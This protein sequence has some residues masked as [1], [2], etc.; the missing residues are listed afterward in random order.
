M[1]E[2]P[3]IAL[4]RHASRP[5]TASGSAS[6]SNARA[7]GYPGAAPRWDASRTDAPNGSAVPSCWHGDCQVHLQSS[8]RRPCPANHPEM[9]TF[10]RPE[11]DV[12]VHQAPVVLLEC[13]IHARLH[14]LLQGTFKDTNRLSWHSPSGSVKCHGDQREVRD[15][16]QP[17]PQGKLLR[18]SRTG[19]SQALEQKGSTACHCAR[20]CVD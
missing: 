12:L 14:Q 2:Q 19:A 5:P 16:L 17:S 18:T 11:Q 13:G 1:E 10:L 6:R 20:P 15:L 3:Q 4:S 9:E 7:R 8:S